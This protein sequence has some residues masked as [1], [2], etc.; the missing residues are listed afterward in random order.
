MTVHHHDPDRIMALAAEELTDTEARLAT[1]E[2][3]GCEQCSTDLEHQ[4]VAFAALAAL[5]HDPAAALTD[6]ESRRLRRSL[7]ETL[8][9][10]AA[11]SVA[12]PD[13]SRR[14]GL[15]W[16]PLVAV[17]A[18]FL[19]VVVG[20]NAIRSL[21]PGDDDDA[22]AEIVAADTATTS[23]PSSGA[24][25]AEARTGDTDDAQ[26]RQSP[27]TTAA[28][29]ADGD[30]ETLL[31]AGATEATTVVLTVADLGLMWD[32]VMSGRLD[33]EESASLGDAPDLA[34]KVADVLAGRAAFAG[35]ADDACGGAAA[36]FVGEPAET[37]IV[38]TVVL[39]DIGESVL[40]VT[41]A[42]DGTARLLVHDPVSC[43]VVT[44]VL[45]EHP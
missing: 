6:L 33:A 16:G 2:V 22:S 24:P 35:V 14:R 12:A 40:T 36:A 37:A 19:A 1:A 34:S 17:A 21:S 25:P 39:V 41:A 3:A 32:E 23:A 11:A 38:G 4:R 7:L 13:V 18:V 27:E 10:A 20:G 45:P 42:P 26:S 8:T 28:A 9:P 29:S 5:G 15:S 43:T 44:E 30:D 31:S